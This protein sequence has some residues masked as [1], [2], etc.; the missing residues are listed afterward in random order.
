MKQ[1]SSDSSKDYDQQFMRCVQSTLPV[2]A[3][4][5]YLLTTPPDECSDECCFC[6]SLNEKCCASESQPTSAWHDKW[7]RQKFANGDISFLISLVRLKGRP[8]WRERGC[9]AI[10]GGPKSKFGAM[11]A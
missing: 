8:R 9:T 3:I 6:L 4:V 7:T 2:G 1:I 11:F 5:V 10:R